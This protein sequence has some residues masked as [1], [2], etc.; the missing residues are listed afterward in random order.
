[1]KL[2]RRQLFAVTGS[3]LVLQ[4]CSR[5]DPQ[6]SA[7]DPTSTG[8]STQAAAGPATPA[9]QSP[10]TAPA[11]AANKK[12]REAALTGRPLP[13]GKYVYDGDPLDGSSLSLH[14]AGAGLTQIDLKSPHLIDGRGAWDRLSVSGLTVFGGE[15]VIRSSRTDG[16]V[17]QIYRVED[18]EF[19][20]YT[21]SA[22]SS[23][24]ED[25]PYWSIEGNVFRA[26]DSRHTIGIALSGLVDGSVV[27]NNKFLLNRVHIKLGRGG[28]NAY[29]SQNDFLQFEKG[30]N[31][32]AVW[33]VPAP[34][35]V[36]SGSGLMID[37]CKFGN[38]FLAPTDHRV[39]YADEDPGPSF[40]QRMPRL[41]VSAGYI[42]GHTVRGALFNGSDEGRKSPIT[43]YTP[44]V[45]ACLYGPLTLAGTLPERILDFPGGTADEGGTNRIGPIMVDDRSQRPRGSN[46]PSAVTEAD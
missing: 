38:E 4:S 31:R 7:P 37:S 10:R 26:Q 20:G 44:H 34:E 9:A 19:Y 6:A 27:R 42:T 24:S 2:H 23:N 39:L 29:I 22:I 35:H 1:M 43:S 45:A 13:A 5:S 40:G 18:C 16:N 28:N 11:S 14:G 33:V 46:V 36:N 15:E 21:R 17:S 30:Q 41:A 8:S 12:I 3:M 25:M 32:C